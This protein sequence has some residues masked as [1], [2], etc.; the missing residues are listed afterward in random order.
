MRGPAG[1]AVGK[2]RRVNISNIIAYNADARYASIIAGIPE[3]QIESVFLNNIRI[4]YRGG[5]KRAQFLNLPP[6]DRE[7]NYPEPSMFGEIPAYGF[8]IRHAKSI[9]LNN[10][11]V[12]Y[13]NDEFRPPFML[14]DVNAIA[15]AHVTAQ[16]AAAVPAFVVR[17]VLDFTTRDFKGLPDMNLERIG[18]GTF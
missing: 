14:I 5:G 9:T 3:H 2:L 12:S 15:F 8:F 6:P 11:E 16:K 10:V 4:Y 18:L 7:T 17:D 13:L 1:T